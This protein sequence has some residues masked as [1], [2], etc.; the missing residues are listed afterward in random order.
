LEEGAQVTI[1]IFIDV[2]MELRQKYKW[3][4]YIHPVV[5]VLNE[6]RNIVKQ[7]NEVYK[8]HVMRTPGLHWLDFFGDLLTPDGTGFNTAYELDGTHM[9][10]TYLPLLE[11]AMNATLGPQ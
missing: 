6:T 2:L 5:P 3:N 1:Q 10:P 4:I 9:N 11:K 7:F 8:E